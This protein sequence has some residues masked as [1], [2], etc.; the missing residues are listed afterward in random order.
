MDYKC[1]TDAEGKFRM[2]PMPS[3]RIFSTDRREMDVS[4]EIGNDGSVRY[5]S[6]YSTSGENTEQAEKTRNYLEIS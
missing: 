6:F 3:L 4:Y 5:Y 2:E 1:I